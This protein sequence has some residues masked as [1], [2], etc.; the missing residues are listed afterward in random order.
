MCGLIILLGVALP[1]TELF[2]LIE[3]GAHIGA[4]STI[5]L[6]MTTAIVGMYFVRG[7]GAKMIRRVREGEVPRQAEVLYGPLLAVAALLLM[8]P[9]FITDSLGALLLIPGARRWTARWIVSRFRPRG[10]PGGGAGGGDE[11]IIVI[12]PR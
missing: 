4:A 12:T 2:L 5:L 9:G 11:Q 10:G 6:V 1:I 3:V 8:L 7:Q